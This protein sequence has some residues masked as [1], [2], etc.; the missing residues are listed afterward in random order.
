VAAPALAEDEIALPYEGAGRSLRIP[1]VFDDVKGQGHE[2]WMLYDTGATY[3]TLSEAALGRLGVPVPVDAPTIQMQTAGGEREARIV[4]LP[5]AWLGGFPVEGI[6]VAVCEDCRADDH[7]G[8]L[9]LN[10]SGQFTVTVDPSRK[11]VVLRAREDDPDRH[12]DVAHWVK[13]AATATSWSD[14]RVEVEV[15]VDNRSDR[16]LRRLDAGIH[17]AEKSFRASVEGVLPGARGTSK[18]S[19]PRGSDCETYRVSIDE[20]RW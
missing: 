1:V 12:L 15:Q 14:G 8:L 4:L 19:L 17:C 16:R 10:V 5:R 11:E 18:V 9:G 7:E 20:A 2:L 6:T 3:S 13:V